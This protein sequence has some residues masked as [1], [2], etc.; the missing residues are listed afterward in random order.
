MPCGGCG[1]KQQ[2][3]PLMTRGLSLIKAVTHWGLSGF[4]VP[5]EEE[6]ERRLDICRGC[7]ELRDDML[8]V[9]CGCPVGRKASLQTEKCPLGKWGPKPS[10]APTP[11]QKVQKP[12]IEAKTFETCSHPAFVTHTYVDR[13]S[14][15]MAL[16]ITVQ[17]RSCGV[18]LLLTDGRDQK[19]RV[20]VS[21]PTQEEMM[22]DQG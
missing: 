12:T 18:L 16:E 7:E 19:L 6:Y 11:V 8:C 22:K 2:I 17:C 14:E 4:P 10:P 3:P 15:P 9:K 20:P 21:L 5:S 13:N 1:N